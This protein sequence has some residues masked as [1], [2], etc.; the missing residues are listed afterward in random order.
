[1]ESA[2]SPLIS[3]L[4][5]SDE[6]VL[7]LN[8]R[9]SDEL[10]GHYQKI[11]REA[12]Y[13]AG[14]K[15]HLGFLT[16]GTTVTDSRSYKIVLLSK[17]A[18]L[19]SAQAV[20]KYFMLTSKDIWLQ[21]LPRFHVGGLA[22]EARAHLAGFNVMT[23][24]GSWNVEAFYNALTATKATWSSLVPTQVYDLVQREFESPKKFRAFVGGGRLS[25]LLQEKA[26]DLGWQLIPTYG[27]TEL[28]SMVATV[29]N[30]QLRF[31]PHIQFMI[32]KDRLALKSKSLLSGYI[33]VVKGQVEL[34]KPELVNGFF[35]TDDAVQKIGQ[36]IM[37]VG[38]SHDVVK[39]GGELVSLNKLRDT[40]FRTVGL[41]YAPFLYLLTIPDD[42]LE[43]RVVLVIQKNEKYRDRAVLSH[44]YPN[45]EIVQLINK[46]HEKVMPFEKIS[47]VFVV[48]QIPRTELGKIQ[49]RGLQLQLKSGQISEV[50]FNA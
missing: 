42:R 36:N 46:Y 39:I 29:E 17:S 32:W 11:F 33:Q 5:Q 10:K 26:K 13:R 1:M 12:T 30:D 18:F 9:M 25:P 8:D 21:C 43:N 48:D 35:V 50:K 16:S 40:W 6:N 24:A 44:F 45:P 47:G 49:D 20:N 19:E 27:L 41:D 4:W 28:A 38:R 2:Q 15:S 23:L 14:I 3:E 34:V 7:F 31:F 22:V 37:F